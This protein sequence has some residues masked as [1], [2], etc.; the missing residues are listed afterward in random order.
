MDH[1]SPYSPWQCGTI[2]CEVTRCE[3]LQSDTV[4]TRLHCT[5]CP[6]PGVTLSWDDA[7][8]A[9]LQCH[10]VSACTER[11]NYKYTGPGGNS[12]SWSLEAV[13]SLLTVMRPLAC[14]LGDYHQ[15]PW[16]AP[17]W[18]WVWLAPD[19]VIISLHARQKWTKTNA[20]AGHGPH[21][22][23]RATGELTSP[24][25]LNFIIH[26]ISPRPLPLP[27]GA[28]NVSDFPSDL[29]STCSHDG[30]LKSIAC[31]WLL[32]QTHLGDDTS[33]CGVQFCLLQPVKPITMHLEGPGITHMKV[34]QSN[35]LSAAFSYGP[36]IFMGLMNISMLCTLT[37][38]AAYF[39]T[40]KECLWGHKNLSS[41]YWRIFVIMP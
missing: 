12:F 34:H 36:L 31:C 41:Q 17:A 27:Y 3:H 14:I 11:I 38:D 9:P 37:I 5:T 1:P 40:R 25:H 39:I 16:P 6:A 4:D 26:G 7:D 22:G 32:Q 2:C 18:P 13:L 24:E 15:W 33:P 30:H 8:D 21:A 20:G 19:H 29:A 10:S 28:P 35:L 23:S